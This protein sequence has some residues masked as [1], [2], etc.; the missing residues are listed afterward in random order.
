[1]PCNAIHRSPLLP[2][3][4]FIPSS[5]RYRAGFNSGSSCLTYLDSWTCLLY[6]FRFISPLSLLFSSAFSALL[7]LNGHLTCL[8]HSYHT[9]ICFLRSFMLN[10]FGF[11][12]LLFLLLLNEHLTCL[13]RTYHNQTYFFFGSFHLLPASRLRVSAFPSLK[14]HLACLAHYLLAIHSFTPFASLKLLRVLDHL[15]RD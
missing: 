8:G 10:S 14:D 6:P 3:A 1:M 5:C 7:L 4:C 11:F 9:W 13:G 15:A 12:A 2:L